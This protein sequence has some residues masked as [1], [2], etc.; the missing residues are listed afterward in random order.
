MSLM[1]MFL[2]ASLA[3]NI[4]LF[5]A[6]YFRRPNP[7]LRAKLFSWVIRGGSQRQV[8]PPPLPAPFATINPQHIHSLLPKPDPGD[9]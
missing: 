7:K 2:G 4:A 5:L 3:L 8:V 9:E 1:D 6:L